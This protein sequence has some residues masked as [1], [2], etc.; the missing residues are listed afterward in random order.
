[1]TLIE[2]MLALSIAA[3]VAT[4]IYVSAR[5]VTRTKAR[6]ESDAERVR[7]AQAALDMFGRDLR[8][9]FLSG[10]KK[11]LQPIVDSVFVG[12]D[13]DPIDRVTVTTFTH[14]HRQ[15]DAN[16]SDQAEVSWFGVDDPRDRRKM[17]LARRESASPDEEPLEGGE[18]RILVHDVVQF[19]LDYYDVERD[20]WDEEWDTTQAGAAASCSGPRRARSAAESTWPRSSAGMQQPIL[21]G[22]SVKPRSRRT[23][24]HPRD[25]AGG[26][27]DH[28]YG[29]RPERQHVRGQKATHI[30]D[31][32]TVAYNALAANLGRLT[33]LRA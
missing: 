12:E 24:R 19:Q 14:V 17:N 27:G 4:F 21:L 10:H 23:R 5:D 7:E 28:L 29:P 9:A 26:H 32:H 15:Y 22:G 3:G 8:C 33:V 13:N 16:D 30:A 20:E 6:I 2:V 31:R 11:P 25:G 18:V 1:M